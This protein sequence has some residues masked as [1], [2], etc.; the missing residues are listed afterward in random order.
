MLLIKFQSVNHSLN[1]FNQVSNMISLLFNCDL[2]LFLLCEIQS[3]KHL[4]VNA[5]NTIVLFQRYF[6]IMDVIGGI[7]DPLVVNF[8]EDESL[9]DLQQMLHVL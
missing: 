3:L 1:F 5:M 9:L 2:L 6:G 4:E 8:N 7:K